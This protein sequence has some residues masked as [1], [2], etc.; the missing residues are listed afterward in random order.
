M[1]VL[2]YFEV[3]RAEPEEIKKSRYLRTNPKEAFVKEFD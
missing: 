2:V 1:S 3:F